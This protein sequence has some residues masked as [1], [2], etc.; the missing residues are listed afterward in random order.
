MRVAIPFDGHRGAGTFPGEVP[1]HLG[2]TGQDDEHEAP[3]C[4]CRVDRVAP[5]VDNVE[6]DARFFPLL[7]GG[8]AIRGV[9]ET[10]IELEHHDRTRFL[11]SQP[12]QELLTAFPFGQWSPTRDPGIGDDL[13]QIQALEGGVCPDAFGLCVEP[14]PAIRL[15]L[16]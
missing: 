10:P 13:G 8:Q 9:S 4:G 3:G 6:G 15:F 12:G 16:R 11:L 2:C 14:E 1:F 7:D 5:K